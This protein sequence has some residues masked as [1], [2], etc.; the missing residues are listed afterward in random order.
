M[1][2]RA[3]TW[4]VVLSSAAGLGLAPSRAAE[5]EPANEGRLSEEALILNVIDY[6]RWPGPER[7]RLLCATAGSARGPALLRA[8]KDGLQARRLEV[9]EIEPNRSPPAECDVLVFEIWELPSQR[10]VLRTLAERPVMTI[11]FG[12]DFC[13]D[14]GLLC[15]TPSAAA[16]ARFEVNLDAVARSGLRINPRVLQLSRPNR[17]P[18]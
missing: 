14:G 11:G 5:H 10:Q 9:Q 15:L 16:R 8:L 1:S 3:L 13:S 6:T 7:P 17:K 18:A 4:F 12:A 2:L